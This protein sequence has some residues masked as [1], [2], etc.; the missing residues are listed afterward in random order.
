M[1][2]VDDF[3]RFV[4]RYGPSLGFRSSR[5]SPLRTAVDENH[6]EDAESYRNPHR[7]DQKEVSLLR[8]TELPNVAEGLHTDAESGEN[9]AVDSPRRQTTSYLA[10]GDLPLVLG[11]CNTHRTNDEIRRDPWP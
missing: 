7:S 9:P 10:I 4:A 5:D 11:N 8:P 3:E 1:F 2:R 6:R